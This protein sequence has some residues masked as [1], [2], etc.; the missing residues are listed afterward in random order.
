MH[1]RRRLLHGE[2]VTFDG[3]VFTIHDVALDAP[4]ND[5]H[6]CSP[7]SGDR[8]RWRLP[9]G[10]ADGVVLAEGLARRTSASRSSTQ[11]RPIRSGVGVHRLA[12]GDDGR[13]MRRIMRPS[14]PVCSTVSIRHPMRTHTS[15]RSGNVTRRGGVDGVADMPAEWWI[16]LGAIGTFDDAVRRRRSAR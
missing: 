3:A 15:T 11:R 16:E 13:E 12:I 9:V 1:G 5:P 8:S 10:V 2:T 4:P 6:P 7:V 14:S